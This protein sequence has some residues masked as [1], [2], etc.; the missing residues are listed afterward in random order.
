[1]IYLASPYT[2][3]EAYVRYQRYVAARTALAAMLRSREWAYSPIVHCHDL[4]R[5]HDMP[6]DA[7]FW[8]D[9]NFYMLGRSTEL[10][11]L[12]LTGWD[13][14]VGVGMELSEAKRLGIPIILI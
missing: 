7:E 3:R 9:Y 2:H 1:M 5:V 13:I 6:T 12:Q 4:A 11:V 14:S 8:K 10:R